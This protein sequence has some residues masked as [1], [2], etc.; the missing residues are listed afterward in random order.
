MSSKFP[1]PSIPTKSGKHRVLIYQLVENP[2]KCYK[3]ERH[4]SARDNT[5]HY[6]V[7]F[8]CENLKR[9]KEEHSKRSL[10]S[11][12]VAIDYSGFLSDPARYQHFCG[13]ED[14]FDFTQVSVQ[15]IY[16]LAFNFITFID[17]ILEM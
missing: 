4:G 2:T 5:Y 17:V 15:G 10:S 11:I 6:Y 7:C 8:A 3:F 12:Y 14:L 1:V 13:D 16:R 9:N